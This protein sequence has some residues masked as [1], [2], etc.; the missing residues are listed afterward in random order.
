VCPSARNS[1]TLMIASM[2]PIIDVLSDICAAARD[3]FD[4]YILQWFQGNCR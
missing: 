2:L 4:P 3:T 1:P